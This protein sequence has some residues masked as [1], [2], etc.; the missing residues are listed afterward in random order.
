MVEKKKKAPADK[1]QQDVGGRLDEHYRSGH[2]RA[3]G[4]HRAQG[5]QENKGGLR[6]ETR[7]STPGCVHE[8]KVAWFKGKGCAE[9]LWESKRSL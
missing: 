2:Y 5:R 8:V 4:R 6:A 7:A 9:E 1:T 3:E